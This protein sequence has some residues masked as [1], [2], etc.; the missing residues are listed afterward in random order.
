MVVYEF[1]TGN[2]YW[3]NLYKQYDCLMK[4]YTECTENNFGVLRFEYSMPVKC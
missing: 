3:Y 4:T 1:L 2:E